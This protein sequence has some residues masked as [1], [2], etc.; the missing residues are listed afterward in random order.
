MRVF[1]SSKPPKKI[2]DTS[3]IDPNTKLVAV[4]YNGGKPPHLFRLLND[5][6]LFEL[7]ASLVRFVDEIHKSSIRPKNNEGIRALLE[8]P[9]EEIR[10]V[11]P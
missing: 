1:I 11:Y 3:A 9:D 6:M 10:L 2:I 4:Y 7:H 5:V 8:E